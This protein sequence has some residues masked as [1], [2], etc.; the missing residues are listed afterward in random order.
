MFKMLLAANES[1]ISW[2]KFIATH[3]RTH[4]EAWYWL[5]FAPDISDSKRQDYILGAAAAGHMKAQHAVGVDVY[6]REGDSEKAAIWFSASAMQG[7][8]FS[9]YYMGLINANPDNKVKS[10]SP[11]YRKAYVWY[12]LA[13]R[14]G[15]VFTPDERKNTIEDL[16]DRLSPHELKW[17]RKEIR[18]RYEKAKSDEGY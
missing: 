13:E 17:A 16:Q 12:K 4:A 9:C 1:A 15:H 7:H 5:T 2:Y 14:F 11:N 3:D 10:A 6:F 18:K 8:A